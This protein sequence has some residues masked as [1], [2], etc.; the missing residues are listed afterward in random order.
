[1]LLII[2][3]CSSIVIIITMSVKCPTKRPKPRDVYN[4]RKPKTID[5][6]QNYINCSA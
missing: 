2:I 6:L 3:I 5:F 4:H 1:M